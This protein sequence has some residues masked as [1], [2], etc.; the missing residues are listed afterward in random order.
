MDISALASSLQSTLG[1]QLPSIFA[2][3]GIIVLGWLIAVLARAATRRLLGLLRVDARI[4]D[5]TG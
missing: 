2:A 1:A 5:S 3:L 4:Q